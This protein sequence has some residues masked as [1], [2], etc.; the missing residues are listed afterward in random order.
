MAP[1][2]LMLGL[3]LVSIHPIQGAF[4]LFFAIHKVIHQLN[5]STT[6]TM[7][8]AL[9]LTITQAMGQHLE[10][11]TTFMFSSIQVEQSA[12]TPHIHTVLHRTTFFV[13]LQ[14]ALLTRSK[15]MVGIKD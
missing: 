5:I 8:V 7:E 12:S 4:C 6:L 14:V 2:T 15:F 13:L 9:D 10:E 1:T 11:V 3:A